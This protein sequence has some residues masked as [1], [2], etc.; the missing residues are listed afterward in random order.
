MYKAS[1]TDE[2]ISFGNGSGPRSTFY[3]IPK[4]VCVKCFNF[5]RKKILF[6]FLFF[7]ASAE[8]ALLKS[9]YPLVNHID[10]YI[11]ETNIGDGLVYPFHCLVSTI[12]SASS[13]SLYSKQEITL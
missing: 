8:Y 3:T 6:Y 5:S 11:S 4:R 2:S 9:S 7:C 13:Y 12:L 1:A 10:Y